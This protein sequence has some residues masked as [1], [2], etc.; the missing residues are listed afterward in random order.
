MKRHVLGLTATA[1]AGVMLLGACSGSG[2]DAAGGSAADFSG[3]AS[4]SLSAWGFENAD[5]VGT[6]RLDYAKKELP[7]VDVQLDQAAFDAQK[8][9]TLVASGNVPDVVQMDR[10]FVA[11]YA[12]QGLI[13]PLDKCY[14]AQDIDPDEAYYPWVADE[15]RYDDKIWGVPQFYQPPAIIVN[16]RV[17]KEAG[18]SA[19]DIDTSD[20]DGLVKAIE[21][22]YQEKGGN[23]TVLGLDPV[24]AGSPELWIQG[25]GGSILDED[26]APTLDTPENAAAIE[27]LKRITDAQG[28]Y[29]KV[30]S[31]GDSFDLFGEKNQFVK[32]QVGAQV[33]NQWYVNVLSPYLDDIDI[34][35]VPFRDKNG[36]PFTVASGQ[37]FVIPTGA[38]NPGA[39]CAWATTLTSLDSWLAAGDAR[40]KTLAD[41]GGVNTGLF[42]GS[43]EADK[44]IREKYVKKTGDAGLDQTIQTFYD[45]AEHGQSIG[46]S[47]AGQQVKDE[48]VNAVTSALLGDKTAEQALAD[49]QE[50]AQRAYD[51]AKSGS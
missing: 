42:T 16:A 33:D 30:K 49:A 19:D 7:D 31:L 32:D 25:L 9:T 44:Q 34:T 21:K 48:L 27:D 3:D 18:V 13:Q 10:R 5:D 20:I 36:E 43:P 23:P 17:L 41:D 46:A 4:G 28:G 26:G 38:K 11:T 6:S 24:A 29:A 15:M 35:A 40:A 12:A 8:F 51:Q 39:A 37:S 50:N 2:T 47:P 22:V 45:V 14:E 1:A